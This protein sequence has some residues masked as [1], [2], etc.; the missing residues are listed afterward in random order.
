MGGR[1]DTDALCNRLLNVKQLAERLRQHISQHTRDDDNGNRDR[2]RTAELFRNTHADGRCD[3]FRQQCYIHFMIQIEDQRQ[4]ENHGKARQHAGENTGEDG[5]DILFQCLHLLIQ[6]NRKADRCRSQQIA[7][8]FC[9][10][11][12]ILIIDIENSKEY[13][14]DCN[15][16]QQRIEN[17][18]PKF[19]L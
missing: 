6:R 15:G 11:I 10:V 13:N 1:S 7:Q 4:R 18:K 17:R 14:D 12:I 16:N 9:T 2:H 3:G 19:F 8:V 5:F